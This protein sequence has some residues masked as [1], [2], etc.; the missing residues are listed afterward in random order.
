MGSDGHSMQAHS[1]FGLSWYF[2]QPKSATCLRSHICS[3]VTLLQAQIQKASRADEKLSKGDKNPKDFI[4]FR[5]GHFS[6]LSSIKDNT[7]T[8]AYNEDMVFPTLQFPSDHAL[9]CS[10]L[11]VHQAP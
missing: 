6:V 9:V 11:K 3:F 10:E 5:K 2:S 8:R 1:A 7:G 4:I